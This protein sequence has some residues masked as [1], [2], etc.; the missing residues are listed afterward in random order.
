MNQ[1]TVRVVFNIGDVR[2]LLK[3]LSGYCD[4][5]TIAIKLAIRKYKTHKSLDKLHDDLEAIS[6]LGKRPLHAMW[7][8]DTR[9][10]FLEVIYPATLN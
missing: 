9:M 7:D 6:D 2:H 3:S 10:S 5:Y 4:P 8:I 1:S